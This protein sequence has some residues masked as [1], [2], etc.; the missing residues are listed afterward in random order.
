M[1]LT[2][3]KLRV[4]VVCPLRLPSAVCGVRGLGE[5]LYA[6]LGHNDAAEFWYALIT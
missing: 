3:A 6:S 4:R 2:P 1:L 5:S